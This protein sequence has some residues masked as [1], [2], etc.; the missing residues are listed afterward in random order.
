MQCETAWSAVVP[1][2]LVACF[3]A[4]STL[5]EMPLYLWA[6]FWGAGSSLACAQPWGCVMGMRGKRSR[7]THGL[8]FAPC[9]S[10]PLWER[11]TRQRQLC[12]SLMSVETHGQKQNT[13]LIPHGWGLTEKISV[14]QRLAAARGRSR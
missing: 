7:A 2:M 5:G 14:L 4:F 3:P 13:G 10:L 6:Q 8:V 11:E 9:T 12:R 1:P